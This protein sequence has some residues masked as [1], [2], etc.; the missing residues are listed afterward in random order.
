MVAV[1]KKDNDLDCFYFNNMGFIKLTIHR[2]S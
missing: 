2:V 1:D